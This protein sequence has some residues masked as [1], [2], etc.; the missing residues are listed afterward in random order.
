[1]NEPTVTIK[2]TRSELILLNQMI[3]SHINDLNEMFKDTGEGERVSPAKLLLYKN[4]SEIEER[5]DEKIRESV[6]DQRIDK[7]SSNGQ[8]EGQ[9][10]EGVCIPCDD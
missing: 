4:L 10:S 7:E 6:N 3:D 2:M 1:M 8:T 5:L 9:S